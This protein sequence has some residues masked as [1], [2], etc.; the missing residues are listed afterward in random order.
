MQKGYTTVNCHCVPGRKVCEIIPN[1]SKQTTTGHAKQSQPRRPGGGINLKQNNM[2][3]KK[4]LAT[5]TVR[6]LALP[7]KGIS[8]L[9]LKI[10]VQTFCWQALQPTK[11]QVE[12]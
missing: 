4:I 5:K 7:G 2:R 3:A 11:R 1:N 8:V 12:N 6:Q 9:L 10:T